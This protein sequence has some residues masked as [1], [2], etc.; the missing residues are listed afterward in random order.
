MKDNDQNNLWES[1]LTQRAKITESTWEDGE[2]IDPDK[3]ND[4]GHGQLQ[5]KMQG[6]YDANQ[7]D[8]RLEELEPDELGEYIN[9][10]LPKFLQTHY[11]MEDYDEL[12][13]ALANAALLLE[14][15]MKR[16]A[17]R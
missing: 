3:F 15:F 13:K 4:S 16:A 5:Q 8:K 14:L 2:P 9:E 1:Y 6:D 17:K 11:S 12:R 7:E 10:A